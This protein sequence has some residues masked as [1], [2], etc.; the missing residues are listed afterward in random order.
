MKLWQPEPGSGRQGISF[1]LLF[2]GGERVKFL[3]FAQLVAKQHLDLL[4]I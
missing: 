1:D 3:L 2:Q 4:T